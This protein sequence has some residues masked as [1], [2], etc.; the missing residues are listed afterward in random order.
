MY[1]YHCSSKNIF[2]ETL[3]AL[4]FAILSERMSPSTENR[5]LGKPHP[6]WGVLEKPPKALIDDYEAF[7]IADISWKNDD[8]HRGKPW[9]IGGYAHD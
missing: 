1:Y 3:S 6:R 2:V 4:I 8:W 5:A 7:I 9:M